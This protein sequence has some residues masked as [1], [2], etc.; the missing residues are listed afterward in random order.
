MHLRVDQGLLA[1]LRAHAVA[2]SPFEACGLLA[3]VPTAEAGWRVTRVE[4]LPNRSAG[5][6]R[7]R[8]DPIDFA[9][10]EHGARCQ[11]EFLAGVFHSHPLT[12]AR[13]SR[14]DLA[15]AWPEH[16][17]LIVGGPRRDLAAYARVDG[18]W[19]RVPLLP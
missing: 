16:V 19:T 4:A 13:P 1:E 14:H 7:F 9:R 6:D 15:R 17:Q 5:A 2:A 12:R 10:A 8:I 3:G 11:G 18:R